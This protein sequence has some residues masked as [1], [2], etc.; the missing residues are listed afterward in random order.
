M[1]YA[2]L[3]LRRSGP[4]GSHSNPKESGKLP[5]TCLFRNRKGAGRDLE[6]G[7]EERT[8]GEELTGGREGPSLGRRA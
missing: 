6:A 4:Y 3:L 7:E 5:E 2:F 8:R 1:G